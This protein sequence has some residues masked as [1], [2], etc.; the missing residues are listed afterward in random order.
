[1]MRFVISLKMSDTVLLSV[2]M[3]LIAWKDSSPTYYVS[4]WT[5]SPPTLFMY[6]DIIENIVRVESS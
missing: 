5:Q 4:D 6:W 3:Q 1:M 2:P